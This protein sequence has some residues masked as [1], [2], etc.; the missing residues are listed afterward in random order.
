MSRF[1]IIAA[2]VSMF[3]AVALG[4]F[5]AHVLNRILPPERFAVFE[6]GV[7]YQIYHGLALFAVAWLIERS[8]PVPAS[9][10]GWLFI[11][12]TMLFSFSLYAL[13]LTE[14]RWCGFVTPFGGVCFLAGWL[15]LAWSAWK[16]I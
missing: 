1:F 14:M 11:A 5:A 13:A 8:S 9:P 15:W 2:S 12:G 16:S 6:V 7:R 10:A 3:L 4:A